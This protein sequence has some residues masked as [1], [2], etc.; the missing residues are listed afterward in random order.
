M[1]K[2]AV[3]VVLIASCLLAVAFPAFG[4]SAT[5]PSGAPPGWPEPIDDSKIHSFVLVDQLEFWSSDEQDALRWDVL[6][7]VG[8]DYNRLWVKTEGEDLTGGAG[9]EL[10]LFDVQ[11]GR[12][13]APFWD[14]LTGVGYQRIWGPGSDPDRFYAVVGLQGLAP[15]WFEVDANLRLS[16]DGDLSADLEAEYDLLLTQ[17]LILQPR[18]ETSVALQEVEE[19]GVGEGFN[20]VRLGAR[21][22]YEIRREIAPY[23]GV[24]WNRKLGDT[25]DLARDEGED[26]ED[27]SLVAGIRL[28]F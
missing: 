19:F 16:E 2:A 5:R 8:G 14:L 28:W 12:L 18:F 6:S 4:E 24:T 22:R 20:S 23:I 3:R 15:Q 17:R 25:A 27:F 13:I 10:E 26:V 11:Y 7:W 21:L 9:G 1:M